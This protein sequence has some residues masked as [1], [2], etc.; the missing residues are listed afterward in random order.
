MGKSIYDF[1][2]DALKKENKSTLQILKEKN[3]YCKYSF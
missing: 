2:V 3:P 1:K